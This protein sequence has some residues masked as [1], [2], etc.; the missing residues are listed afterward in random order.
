[1]SKLKFSDGITIDTSGPY[2]VISVKDSMY[3]AG[4]GCCIPVENGKEAF[5]IMKLLKENK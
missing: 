1:M 2:R 4:H 3:V 5:E